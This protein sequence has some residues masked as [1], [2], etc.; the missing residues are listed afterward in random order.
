MSWFIT[1]QA[2]SKHTIAYFWIE[3][4]HQEQCLHFP[5]RVFCNPSMGKTDKDIGNWIMKYRCQKKGS[6]LMTEKNK[7]TVKPDSCFYCSWTS[8]SSSVDPVTESV[9]HDRLLSQ[10]TRN[11]LVK[12]VSFRCI[13]SWKINSRNKWN[14]KIT[15]S[16]GMVDRI[17]YIQM[18]QFG[19]VDSIKLT[20]ASQIEIIAKRLTVYGQ[21][22]LLKSTQCLNK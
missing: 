6:Y 15:S 8:C 22:F 3:C 20:F 11:P 16:S 14:R 19:K 18:K 12:L 13:F 2:S 1:A 7:V 4:L 5:R 10:F 21:V 17:Q 9:L